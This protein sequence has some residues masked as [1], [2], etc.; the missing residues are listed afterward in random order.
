MSCGK[1]PCSTERDQENMSCKCDSESPVSI[2]IAIHVPR[3]VAEKA[4]RTHQYTKEVGEE[5]DIR[6]QLLRHISLDSTFLIDGQT[7]D[8]WMD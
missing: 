2:P 8:E 1:R 5:S 4:R 6:D 7:V 3:P